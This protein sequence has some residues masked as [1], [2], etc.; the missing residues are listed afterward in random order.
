M[1]AFSTTIT[2]GPSSGY[3]LIVRGLG[4]RGDTTSGTSEYPFLDIDHI[5]SFNP[6]FHIGR[7]RKAQEPGQVFI[8]LGHA[9]RAT[10]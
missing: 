2:A 6:D 9:L 10:R 8:W 4:H 3:A 7:C 5:R 1:P